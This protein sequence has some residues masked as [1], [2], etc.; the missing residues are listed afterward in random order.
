MLKVEYNP[1][2]L[3]V[4]QLERAI[5]L[6]QHLGDRKKVLLELQTAASQLRLLQTRQ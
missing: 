4:A 6:L 3:G 2:A 1:S 5:Y